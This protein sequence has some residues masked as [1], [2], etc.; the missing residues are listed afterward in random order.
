[1]TS[2]AAD[3]FFT[4]LGECITSWA[5]V[6]EHLFEICVRSLGATRHRV[7]I[8]YY[9]TPTLDARLQLTNELVRTVLLPRDPPAGDH[10][11]PDTKKWDEIHRQITKLLPVRNRM[12]HHPVTYKD[13]GR[14]PVLGLGGL[15]PAQGL[16][17]PMI[18]SWYESYVSEAEKLR[19]RH[20]DIKPLIAS[21]LS[22]HRAS[23]ESIIKQ[24]DLFRA[25]VLSKYPNID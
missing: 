12:A 3:E 20:K 13:L 25:R 19:G 8:V 23:V 16:A 24:L 11:H 7:A 15:A 2:D 22:R 9:R 6:E 1:M 5:Q 14:M 4:W 10:N 17:L 18:G 21:D